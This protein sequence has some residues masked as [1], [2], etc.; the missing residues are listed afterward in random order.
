MSSLWGIFFPPEETLTQKPSHLEQCSASKPMHNITLF[1]APN[2]HTKIAYF[3]K[4]NIGSVS[5]TMIIMTS[6]QFLERCVLVPAD[7]RGHKRKILEGT[8]K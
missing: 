8:E 7:V 2:I 5:M 3:G 4:E 6:V 1:W